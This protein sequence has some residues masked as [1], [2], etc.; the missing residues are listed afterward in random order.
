MGSHPGH[1]RR[2]AS[3]ANVTQEFFHP[4]LNFLSIIRPFYFYFYIHFFFISFA[5]LSFAYERRSYCGT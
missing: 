4:E 1:E 3:S 5:I 2:G